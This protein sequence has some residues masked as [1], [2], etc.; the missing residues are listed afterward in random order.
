MWTADFWFQFKLLSLWVRDAAKSQVLEYYYLFSFAVK[1]L[2][3]L[4]NYLHDL[5]SKRLCDQY[6]I[7]HQESCI[8]LLF[9]L[10]MLSH[11]LQ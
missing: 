11:F 2:L 7:L 8:R 9:I 1:V 10:Q 6:S 4:Q 3:K 5:I